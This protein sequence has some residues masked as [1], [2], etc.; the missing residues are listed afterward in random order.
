MGLSRSRLF[1]LLAMVVVLCNPA[2]VGAENSVP[3]FTPSSS[4]PVLTPSQSWEGSKILQVSVIFDQGGY[5]AWY[6]AGQISGGA[7]ISSIGYATSNDGV[8]WMKY[9]SNP[10]FNKGSSAYSTSSFDSDSVSFPTVVKV[11]NQYYM[12]YRGYDGSN[13]RI[14]LATS[15]DGLS[16]T[17]YSSNPLFSGSHPDVVF[18]NNQWNMWYD[19]EGSMNYATS[20]DGKAWSQIGSGIVR[21]PPGR[22]N[23]FAP[24]VVYAGGVFHMWFTSDNS[25]NPKLDLSGLFYATSNDGKS[26]SVNAADPLHGAIDVGYAAVVIGSTSYLWYNKGTGISLATTTTPIPEFGVTGGN[27]LLIFAV[28]LA[29]GLSYFISRKARKLSEKSKI[30]GLTNSHSIYGEFRNI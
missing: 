20:P 9:S 12:Y 3:V 24:A 17:R 8:A 16:W 15:N 23:A 10:A 7:F 5:K 6:T 18:A 28:T 4:N 2:I 21:T 11:G 19:V 30:S 22:I 27:L 25:T 14:G 29:L 1:G 26:W 13:A